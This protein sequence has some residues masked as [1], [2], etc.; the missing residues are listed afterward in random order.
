MALFFYPQRRNFYKTFQADLIHDSSPG[1]GILEPQE[2]VG[3]IAKKRESVE[4]E[5]LNQQWREFNRGAQ[6]LHFSRN[7]KL[8]KLPLALCIPGHFLT[9]EW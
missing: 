5:L 2:N 9:G 3:F 7:Y 1:I 8:N 4:E 6:G